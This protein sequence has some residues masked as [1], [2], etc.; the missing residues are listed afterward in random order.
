MAEEDVPLKGL[1]TFTENTELKGSERHLEEK[2]AAES[3]QKADKKHS[4]IFY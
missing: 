1:S 3:S 2:Q 4:S